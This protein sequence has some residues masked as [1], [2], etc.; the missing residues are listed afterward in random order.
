MNIKFFK[1]CNTCKARYLL[2]HL[3]SDCLFAQ[4][5]LKQLDEV[6]EK[7]GQEIVDST[8]DMDAKATFLE[9]SRWKSAP[10]IVITSAFAIGVPLLWVQKLE[11]V[12]WI[13]IV[14]SV[15]SFMLYAIFLSQG[16]F[17][18]LYKLLIVNDISKRVNPTKQNKN[19][20]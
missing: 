3:K 16:G 15:I 13:L 4:G 8:K 6:S 14:F 9:W 1:A 20:G 19:D 10:F 11:A 18:Q 7:T 5:V 12:A 2:Y 17:D